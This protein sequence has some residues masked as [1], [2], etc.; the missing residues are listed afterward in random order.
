MK[1]QYRFGHVKIELNMPERMPVPENMQKFIYSDCWGSI[2]LRN[3]VWIKLE[4]LI[5]LCKYREMNYSQ[6]ASDVLSQQKRSIKGM[7]D[8]VCLEWKR[9]LGE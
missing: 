3:E 1:K 8:E 6:I 5:P 4:N 7:S 9:I 2:I